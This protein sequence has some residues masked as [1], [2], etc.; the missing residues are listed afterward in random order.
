MGMPSQKSL[1]DFLRVRLIPA[2]VDPV[3]LVE[4]VAVF[5]DPKTWPRVPLKLEPGWVGTVGIH[6]K[7]TGQF[8]DATQHRFHQLVTHPSVSVLGE[9]GVDFTIDEKLHARQISTLRW[10]LQSYRFD[11]L[12]VLHIRGDRLDRVH[13]R[14]HQDVLEVMRGIAVNPDQLIHLHCFQGGWLR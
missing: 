12:V 5:C 9:M 1:G 10:A 4:G 3:K 6:P 8:E 11:Q 14:S 13:G 7:S 2:H